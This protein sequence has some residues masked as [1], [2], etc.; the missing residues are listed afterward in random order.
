MRQYLLGVAVDNLTL[1]ESVDRIAT[2][3]DT[4]HPHQHV[5]VNAD[6][7]VKAARDPRL[8]SVIASCD[9]INADG[10][11]VVWASHLLGQPLK[12]RVTGIDLFFRLLRE[13]PARGWR[14]YLLGARPEVLA[15]C[16]RRAQRDYPGLQ[17][18]GAHHG[19]WPPEEETALVEQIRAAQPDLL[20]VAMGS[21][22]KELFLAEH[23][24]TMEVPFA[25][26]VGGSFDVMAGLTRRA[27]RWMQ[28][29]GLEWL[30]RLLQ[31]P[32]RMY[33]RYLIEDMQF[34]WLLAVA[35]ARRVRRA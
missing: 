24:D 5:V 27:P 20:F 18:A 3:V 23:L 17:I 12:E 10:M 26:G 21:P 15:E 28:K 30:Y 19:Y 32:R 7:V 16:V 2:F 31:E 8:A 34:F 1:D 22:R 14:V 33:R 29:T 25:M 35:M 11:P 4:G 6:K 13:A 9:L